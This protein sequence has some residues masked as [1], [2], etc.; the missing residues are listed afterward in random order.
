MT[1]NETW[2]TVVACV[3][4]LMFVAAWLYADAAAGVADRCITLL[5]ECRIDRRSAEAQRDNTQRDLDDL[6]QDHDA[7]IREHID[8]LDEADK[9]IAKLRWRI[10]PRH[11]SLITNAVIG[12]ELAASARGMKHAPMH[13]QDMMVARNAREAAHAAGQGVP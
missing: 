9:Q 11:R 2:L 12:L 10:N 13:A 3:G 6:W 5:D 8:A 7:L 4:W 1:D